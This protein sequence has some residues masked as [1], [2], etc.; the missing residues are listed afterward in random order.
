MTDMEKVIRGLESHGAGESLWILCHNC[1]YCKEDIS[2]DR[3]SNGCVS[4]L[5]RD[6]LALLRQGTVTPTRMNHSEKAGFDNYLCECKSELYYK[7][8]YCDECGRAVK[9]SE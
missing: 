2:M 5:M 7:Q 3:T 4:D 1:P 6:A 8:K 9:W